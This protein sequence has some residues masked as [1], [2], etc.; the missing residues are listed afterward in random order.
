MKEPCP[1]GSRRLFAR[2]CEPYLNGKKV[3]PTAEA[4]MRSR[5]SAFHQRDV[6]YLIRTHHPDYRAPDEERSLHKSA[7]NTQWLNLIVLSAQ[8]GQR[9]DSKGSVEFAAAYQTSSV[10]G[11]TASVKQLHERSDFVKVS[12]QWLYTEG[13]MQPPFL[14]KRDQSCWCGSGKKFRQCHG[15]AP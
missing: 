2:C 6:S 12:G 5:Y 3:A 11:A 13:K 15:T 14:P 10:L 9:K 7:Q 1:C 4:L 8:K